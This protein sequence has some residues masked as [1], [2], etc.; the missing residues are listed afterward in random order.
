VNLITL[1]LLAAAL[2]LDSLTVGLLYGV[3]GIR[4]SLAAML[5]VSVATGVLLLIAMGGGHALTTV[6]PPAAAERLGAL[7]LT[8]VGA[9]VTYQTWRS[10]RRNGE[11]ALPPAPAGA[12]SRVWRLRLG[13]VGIVVEILREPSSADL[14]RSGHI[15]P[16]EAIFLGVALALDS[17]AAGLGAAMSGFSP[18]TLPP[19]AAAGSFLLMHLGSRAARYLPCRLQGSWEMLHGLVLMVLGVYRMVVA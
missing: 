6:L 18:Y 15:G 12:Q 17:V 11:P 16:L 2:S 10:H 13:S 8:G 9:W 19:A 4:L 14:D 5:I 7:I 3:R 1:F